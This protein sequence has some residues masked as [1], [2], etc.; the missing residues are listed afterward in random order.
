[1]A[2]V[3]PTSVSEVVRPTTQ[4]PPSVWGHYF[5]NHLQDEAK[6]D[7]WTKRAGVLRRKV[8]E[9]LK[10]AQGNPEEIY[11]LDAFNRLGLSYQF[12]KEINDALH[13]IHT[14]YSNDVDAGD[15]YSEATRFRVLRE[16]GYKASTDVFE[17]FKDE[18][19]KTFKK[20]LTEDVKGL[21]SLY[22]AAFL[23]IQGEYIL[24]EAIAFTSEHLKSSLPNLD[25][26]L[27]KQVQRALELPTH[28]RLP[29][30]NVRYFISLYEEIDDKTSEDMR[31]LLE[32]AKLDFNLFQAVHERDKRMWWKENGLAEKLSYA[33]NRVV[34]CYVWNMSVAPEPHLSRARVFAAKTLSM[35]SLTDDTY[36][37]YGV[38]EELKQYTEAIERWDLAAMDELPEY[39]K[40]L[41]HELITLFK[42]TEEELE[43]EGYSY[44]IGY[45]KQ[46]LQDLCRAYFTEQEWYHN[47]Y[48]PGTE[49]YIRVS[50]ISSGY[51]AAFLLN[52]VCMKDASIEAFKW[53]N[54]RPRIVMA[55][56]E[57][58]RFMDDLVSNEFEQQRG[59]VVSSIEC[60]MKE[61]G[62]TRQE[63]EDLFK[64]FYDTAWKDINQA[65]LRPTPFPMYI[66]SKAVNLARVIDG[67]YI[68][69]DEDR[70]TF[71]GGSTKEM[72]TAL[73]VDPIPV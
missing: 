13:R 53:G 28:K 72:I 47:R 44:Q 8:K 69:N 66:L 49:E 10:H 43:R 50:L 22:E 33:R 59:H 37:A 1:M 17:K 34:E 6:L 32:Y 67:W 3:T 7:Q 16:G 5:V 36:D 63:V 27:A 29:R 57:L 62:M 31:T 18:Q 14:T 21:L 23:G 60:F 52:M 55:S 61:K 35:I 11:F 38:Y 65:C 71:S 12:E 30:V 58:A 9:I 64:H 20:S 42:E 4:F 46:A 39:L 41:Y 26:L 68:C 73:L 24:D 51:P 70:Y 25:P 15:L 45:S 2:L 56:A 19:G 54:S 48:T 40:P